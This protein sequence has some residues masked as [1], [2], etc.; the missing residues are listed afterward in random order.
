MFKTIGNRYKYLREE[1]TQN[2]KNGKWMTTRELSI[3]MTGYEHYASD[4]SRIENSKREPNIKDLQIYHKYFKTLIPNF[5]YEFLLGET[6]SLEYTNITISKDLGLSEDVINAL[7]F[8]SEEEPHCNIIFVLNHIFKL[9][10]GYVF[11]SALC[12]YFYSIN[13]DL[14]MS[15]WKMNKKGVLCHNKLEGNSISLLSDE[16]EC[17]AQ[18]EI[19]DVEYIFQ[20]KLYKV[21]STI[22]ESLKEKNLQC[23]PFNYNGFTKETFYGLT[24]LSGIRDIELSSMNDSDFQKLLKK[25]RVTIKKTM[26]RK[27]DG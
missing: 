24:C 2:N 6:D 9:G 1:H 10:Y 21:L 3:A 22:R 7:K 23:K 25:I 16:N 26:E 8:W 20:Q 17:I 4:I 18:I 13:P 5:S 27:A 11:L 14:K 12:H 15:Q 19:K